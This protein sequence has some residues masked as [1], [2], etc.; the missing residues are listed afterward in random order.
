MSFNFLLFCQ[1]YF[2]PLRTARLERTT[3]DACLMLRRRWDTRKYISAGIRTQSGL[4]QLGIWAWQVYT[5]WNLLSMRFQK[6][7]SLIT[8]YWVIWVTKRQISGTVNWT[9]GDNRAEGKQR[10]HE[11]LQLL[12][13]TGDDLRKGCT[14]PRNVFYNKKVLV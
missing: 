13:I 6:D 2:F 7:T 9:V 11:K 3:T 8:S 5:E 10:K 4:Q 12:L 1:S 14:I